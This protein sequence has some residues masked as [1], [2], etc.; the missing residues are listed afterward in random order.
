MYQSRGGDARTGLVRHV[1][2]ARELPC[3]PPLV[4]RHVTGESHVVTIR[5]SGRENSQ[6]EPLPIR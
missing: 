2:P 1:F 6:A 3:N 4:I 5:H